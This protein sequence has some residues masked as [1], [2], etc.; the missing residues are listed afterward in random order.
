MLKKLTIFFIYAEEC[1][2]CDDMRQ[3]LKDAINHSSYDKGSCIIEEIDSSN[4]SAIEI[5]L[6]NDID[7]LPACVI[8]SFSFCGKDSYDYDSILN[9]IEQTW[10]GDLGGNYEANSGIY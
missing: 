5:A 4:D 10:E 1:K 9:A 2:D 6:D 8:G 7:D 3:I